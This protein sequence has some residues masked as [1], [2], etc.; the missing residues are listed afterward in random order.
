MV[1]KQYQEIVEACNLPSG[2]FAFIYGGGEVGDQL[3]HSD[4]DLICFTGSTKT[5]KYLYNVCAEKMIK[6]LLELG[7]SAPGIVFKD[8]D[9]DVVVETVFINRFG[10][11]GQICDGLKRLIVH[12]SVA[13]EFIMKMKAKLTSMKVGSPIDED[14]NIGPLVAQRQLD[15]LE[16]Q[17]QDA[18]ENGAEVVLGG[19]KP[20]HLEG[21][22]YLPTILTGVT[23]EMRVWSEEVF[24]PVLPIMSFKTYA[25]AI[26]LANDTPYG[27]GGYVFTNDKE[28]GD[29]VAG[30]IKTGMVSINGAFYVIPDDPFGGCKMSGLGREH[31]KWGIHELT[32]VKV[33]AK[34]K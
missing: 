27:L 32:N 19:K 21:V 13:N 15:F 17:V 11:C 33:I 16:G 18:L 30:E 14:T 20:A 31:G 26:E 1:C 24:G 4:I 5:G 29:K 25:E 10:N 9:L 2:V 3:V 34:F 23:R 8:A 22:Y 7:G 12:E 6:I 28:L